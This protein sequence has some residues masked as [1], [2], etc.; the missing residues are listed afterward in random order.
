LDGAGWIHRA[1]DVTS[2]ELL[3]IRK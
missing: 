1:Q 3:W 2:G